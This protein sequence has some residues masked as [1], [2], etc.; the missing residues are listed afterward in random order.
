MAEKAKELKKT[1]KVTDKEKKVI[2]KPVDVSGV[3]G[4]GLRPHAQIIRHHQ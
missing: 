3:A 2:G 4:G 1:K